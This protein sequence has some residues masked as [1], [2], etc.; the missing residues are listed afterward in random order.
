MNVGNSNNPQYSYNKDRENKGLLKAFIEQSDYIPRKDQPE[1]CHQFGLSF[2]TGK[3]LF[4]K[5]YTQRVIKYLFHNTTTIATVEKYTGIPQKYLCQ[6][7][8]SLENNGKL[9]V[10]SL[11]Y[12]P[13]T[14]S[15][16]VQFVSTNPE[17]W[18]KPFKS[19]NNT[20][21]LTLFK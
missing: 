21:Q 5:V 17:K 2:E 4:G 7:K 19:N 10:V 12:C 3:S 8:A 18:G 13:T 20:N 11:G 14:L 6:V 15:K 16:N 1:A 9:Q